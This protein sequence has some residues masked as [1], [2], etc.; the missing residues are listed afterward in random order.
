MNS[1]PDAFELHPDNRSYGTTIRYVPGGGL[2]GGESV[3]D[4]CRPQ[5]AADGSLYSPKGR[6]TLPTLCSS[7]SYLSTGFLHLQSAMASALGQRAVGDGGGDSSLG[8]SPDAA[9]ANVSA[10]SGALPVEIAYAQAPLPEY[11]RGF[12]S[13]TMRLFAAVYLTGCL[14]NTLYASTRGAPRVLLR[15]CFPYD[16]VGVVN[17]DP[18]GL[19]P[20]SLCAHTSL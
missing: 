8:C 5:I 7:M 10:S 13:V 20:S 9:A 17:A 14:V 18:E 1:T 4:E 3:G 12:G 11:D 6:G 16:R 15:D 2:D 19:L